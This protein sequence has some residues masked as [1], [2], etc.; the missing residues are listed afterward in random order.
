MRNDGSI[1]SANGEVDLTLA[2]E[3][4]SLMHFAN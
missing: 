2:R 4:L 1:E 3:S